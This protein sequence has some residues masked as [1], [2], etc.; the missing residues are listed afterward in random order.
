MLD[1]FALR[2]RQCLLSSVL[3]GYSLS[4]PKVTSSFLDSGRYRKGSHLFPRYSCYLRKTSQPSLVLTFFAFNVE[5]GLEQ[6]FS[7]CEPL[8][9]RLSITWA[10]ARDTND[11]F[12]P[13][14]IEL[15]TLRM[16]PSNLCF[17]K[18]LWKF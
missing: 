17:N 13:K 2:K 10:L 1:D 7:K 8:T 15:G 6:W 18:L 4:D 9:K 11:Q 3:Y 14:L 5:T 16:G 12:P